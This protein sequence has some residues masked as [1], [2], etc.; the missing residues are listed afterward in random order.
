MNACPNHATDAP[1]ATVLF[2]VR[3]YCEP[4]ALFLSG[5]APNV[6]II[7]TWRITDGYVSPEKSRNRNPLG[8]G[9]KRTVETARVEIAKRRRAR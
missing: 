4:C 3:F 2:G 7:S 8:R 5:E 9:N 6:R 1:P